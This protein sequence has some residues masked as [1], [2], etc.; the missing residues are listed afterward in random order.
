ML[1]VF[2][3]TVAGGMIVLYFLSRDLLLSSFRQLEIQQ[4]EQNVDYALNGLGLEYSGVVRTT[5]DYAYWDRTY[6]FMLA[7]GHSEDIGK[8]FPNTSMEGLGLNLVVLRDPL[9]KIVYAKAYDSE[10][11]QEMAVPTEFLEG[12]F[13]RTPMRLW[14][15]LPTTIIRDV[16]RRMGWTW[17]CWFMSLICLR[18]SGK[19]SSRG[20]RHRLSTWNSWNRPA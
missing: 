14:K 3:A 10:K 4:M 13:S 19:P 8:E 16:S 15:P 11:R 20:H 17:S 12:L 9:G 1:L 18:T 7:P 2:A 6:E 5:S